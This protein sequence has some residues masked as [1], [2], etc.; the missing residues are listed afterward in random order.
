MFNPCTNTYFISTS[1]GFTTHLYR[2]WELLD[3]QPP[4]FHNESIIWDRN[5]WKNDAYK[6]NFV[7]KNKL[8][9][10]EEKGRD[11]ESE[12]AFRNKHFYSDL[13]VSVRP[14]GGRNRCGTNNGGCSHLC[15]PSNK[16]YTCA[17]PTG[18]KKVDHHSC[19]NS[20]SHINT[21][22]L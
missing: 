16:T 9:K 1:C 12:T 14:V 18:F 17:C 20:E 3:I 21:L 19:A 2:L 13:Y 8:C 5:S 15:L 4:D 7:K 10:H 6:T 22:S 11:A